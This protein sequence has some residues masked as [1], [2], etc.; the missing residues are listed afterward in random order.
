MLLLKLRGLVLLEKALLLLLMKYKNW[1]NNHLMPPMK[2]NVR[3][4]MYRK[5]PMMPAMILKLFIQPL[6]IFLHLIPTLPVQ[7]KHSIKL[8]MKF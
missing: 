8:L 3:L 1:Q 6:K 5:V 4:Q 7:L 2:L